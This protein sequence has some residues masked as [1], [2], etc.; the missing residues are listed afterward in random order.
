MSA[1]Q[2]SLVVIVGVILAACSATGAPSLSGALDTAASTSTPSTVP[3]APTAP[4]ASAGPTAAPTPTREPT[5]T[6]DPTPQPTP[7]KPTGAKV[8][9]DSWSFCD[10]SPMGLC[11]VAGFEY[12]AKW[13]APR[14]KGVQI[15]VYGV[16]E[17]FAND[18]DGAMID[19]WCLRPHTELP[20]SVLV[21]LAKAPASKGSVTWRRDV[22]DPDEYDSIVLAA[23]DAEGRHSIF[24]IAHTYAV[25]DSVD[26]VECPEGY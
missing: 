23:Y 7:A 25:C 9:F 15:R 6:A 10:P 1:R 11:E 4:V 3:P 12:T 16:T 26:D 22:G 13:K 14:T 8:K 21:L 19:G 20:S 17:C 24:A 18:V 2:A 5:P